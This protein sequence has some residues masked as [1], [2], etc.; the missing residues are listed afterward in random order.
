MDM[1]VS[2]D[3]PNIRIRKM[4]TILVEYWPVCLGPLDSIKGKVN[5]NNPHTNIAWNVYN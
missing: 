4:I 5:G 2:I 1:N 3:T